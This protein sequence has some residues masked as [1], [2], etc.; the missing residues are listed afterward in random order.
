MPR[1]LITHLEYIR[2]MHQCMDNG[3]LDYYHK[4]L[5]EHGRILGQYLD[6]KERR[7]CTRRRNGNE[8]DEKIQYHFRL[9]ELYQNKID[10]V[11]SR[12]Q[13]LRE[14]YTYEGEENQSP[15][16]QVNEERSNQEA[17]REDTESN[18]D[19][20]TEPEETE[21]NQAVKQEVKEEPVGLTNVI[22]SEPF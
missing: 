7:N 18:Q 15:S 4:K 16:R 5:Q 21:S 6:A 22:K 11:E 9:K 17:K 14:T 13:S 3:S 10:R 2:R 20:K 12:L 1:L 8:L 19:V